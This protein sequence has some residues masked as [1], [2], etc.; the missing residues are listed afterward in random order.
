MISD[1]MQ[2]D[3]NNVFT[4]YTC[5]YSAEEANKLFTLQEVLDVIIKYPAGSYIKD[6]AKTIYN[7]RDYF[8]RLYDERNSLIPVD[9]KEVIKIINN[10][11]PALAEF[12]VDLYEAVNTLVKMKNNYLENKELENKVEKLES[13][14]KNLKAASMFFMALSI[15]LAFIHFVV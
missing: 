15:F 4:S 7:N 11:L 13:Y 6:I 1:T 5:N 9:N 14:S 3:I 12:D 10:K 8:I 2:K